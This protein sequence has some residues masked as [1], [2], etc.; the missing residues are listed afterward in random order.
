MRRFR[1]AR[2]LQVSRYQQ[3]HGS[4]RSEQ[5]K[6]ARG[7]AHAIG[8]L[9]QQDSNT[10]PEQ[11][12]PRQITR[13]EHLIRSLG[14]IVK[15]CEADQQSAG[16]TKQRHCE[17]HHLQQR[18]DASSWQESQYSHHENQQ[19]HAAHHGCTSTQ[20]VDVQ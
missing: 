6:S 10:E 18:R 20:S 2:P 13:C 16:A 17:S 7:W 15:P 1:P 9:R 4:A 14:Q 12:G 8:F 5:R 3:E 11:A 19:A